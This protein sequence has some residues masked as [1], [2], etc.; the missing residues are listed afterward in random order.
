MTLSQAKSTHAIS[1]KDAV[2]LLRSSQRTGLSHSEVRKRQKQYGPN[3]IAE[4]DKESIVESVI[5]QLI[6]PLALILIAAFVLTIVLQ[7]Y[8]DAGVILV[9]TVINVV[10]SL[11]QERR[12][13]DAFRALSGSRSHTAVVLRDG[14]KT[15]VPSEELVPGDIV[16]LQSGS[17]VPADGRL[18]SV[19]R[20][21]INQV[22]FTGESEAVDKTTDISHEDHVFD[23]DNMAFMGS[24][25]MTGTGTMVVTK[26]GNN[27]EFGKIA[28]QLSRI[29]KDLSPVQTSMKT[30][31]KW[32]GLITLAAL[33]VLF[34]VGVM[35]GMELYS[36]LLLAVAVGVSAVPE[37][38][39]S[40]VTV[41]LA[42]GARSVMREGGL[43]KNLASAETLGSATYILTDKTGTLTY[44]KMKTENWFTLSSTDVSMDMLQRAAGFATDMFFDPEG[45]NF[46]GDE[47]D[48]AIAH[49]VYR[50][51]QQFEEIN[52][53]HHVLDTIPFD[54]KY[55]FFASL[56][57]ED[58]EHTVYIKGAP[59]II[60]EQAR[61]VYV[62]GAPR[63]ISDQDREHFRTI[64]TTES[65]RGRRLLAV[66]MRQEVGT[67]DLSQ[68]WDAEGNA[69]MGE[70]IVLCGLVSFYDRVRGDVPEVVQGMREDAQTEVIMITGDGPETAHRIALESGIITD[71]KEAVYTGRDIDEAT[72]EHLLEIMQSGQARVFARVTPDHKLRLTMILQGAG[73]VVAMT[74][75]GVNDAPALQRA[76]I[77]ISLSSSTEVAKEAADLVL[78]NDSFATI[79]YAIREGRRMT[80]NLK[81]T[82]IY[83]LSTSF[84][85][86][87]VL[88]GALVVAGP[89]PFYP[90]QIL[91]ANIIEEGLMNFAFIFEPAEKFVRKKKYGQKIVG[92]HTR[93][94]VVTVGIVNGAILLSFYALLLQQNISDDLLRTYMFAAL[95][96]DS[97][98]F[99]LTLKSLYDPIWRLKLFSNMYL[100]IA[101]AVSFALLLLALELPFLRTVL[102]LEPLGVIGLEVVFL[103]GVINLLAVEL[104]KRVYRP[105]QS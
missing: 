39:L 94:M 89:V 24:T 42:F 7:E 86:V 12:A 62:D 84:S 53:S 87:I 35:Q 16:E 40:A 69:S 80:G 5:K 68:S 74:G 82:I 25:V 17:Y 97:I 41:V 81:K 92:R 96:I 33:V 38:L 52:E 102:H 22:A 104:V 67:D 9:A 95:S 13:G 1:S 19:A 105:T 85:E 54:S 75:D 20:L 93:N 56:R 88:L 3:S 31:A 2:V 48:V 100:I 46:V 63:E 66:A 45:K 6:N 32:L 78:V 72:D 27:S 49:E 83:L 18:L 43:V 76:T 47:M 55:K 60:I 90:T 71:E 10:I 79:A 59:D 99:G 36:A 8:I 73:E 11:Y 44:G 101:S 34:V 50:N 15:V 65:E 29:T 51:Q 26:T 28:D 77:G 64:V 14:H 58:G 37:G 98:F 61:Y 70:H 21:S 91:W 103:F 23:R 4:P 57:A 30:I